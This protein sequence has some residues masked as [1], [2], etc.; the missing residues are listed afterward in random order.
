M[1]ARLRAEEAKRVALEAERRAAKE[2]AERQGIETSTRV[3]ARV[4]QE[5]AAERQ[6]NANSGTSNELKEFA[7][8]AAKKSQSASNFFFLKYL[9]DLVIMC[10]M[11]DLSHLR[12][13]PS[14]AVSIGNLMAGKVLRAAESA[15]NLEQARLQKVKEVD[16]SNQALRLTYNK[17]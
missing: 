4:A 1:Q 2:A 12:F 10:F 9:M 8:D 17:V 7:S 16:E 15:L 3:A 14:S 6:M 13:L 5:E 11:C